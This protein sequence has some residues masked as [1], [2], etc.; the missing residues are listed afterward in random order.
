ME[1]NRELKSIS[2]WQ[3]LLAE[4]GVKPLFVFKHSTTCPVSAEAH[5]EY[6]KYLHKNANADVTHAH[7]LVIESRPV[8]NAIAESLEL[9]HES[10]QAIYIKNG[11]V[12]W[13]ASHWRI[14]EQALRENLQ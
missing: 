14:T 4:S 10:P 5:D 9:K 2:E 6:E 7:V 3:T 11:K 1:T 13:H 12:A 8:S